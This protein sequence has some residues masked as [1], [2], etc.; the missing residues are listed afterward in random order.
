M[1]SLGDLQDLCLEVCPFV[2]DAE[3][4]ALEALSGPKKLKWTCVNMR[5]VITDAG[6]ASL[7]VL[8]NLQES[9]FAVWCPYRVRRRAFAGNSRQLAQ[10]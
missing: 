3:V 5:E 2:S 10:S 9:F 4:N 7:T 1:T 6:V 8:T